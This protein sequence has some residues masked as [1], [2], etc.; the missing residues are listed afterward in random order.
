MLCACLCV[1]ALWCFQW[2][3]AS[4]RGTL[5]WLHSL[6]IPATVKTTQNGNIQTELSVLAKDV[7]NKSCQIVSG[8]TL[9]RNIY[10][11]LWRDAA[12]PGG[13]LYFL[14]AVSI[15]H[16]LLSCYSQHIC[17]AL[18]HMVTAVVLKWHKQPF[19][20]W[21]CCACGT[22]YRTLQALLI[23]NRA[24]V[25]YSNSCVRGW[26][27]T[28]GCHKLKLSAM[29]CQPWTRFLQHGC[30]NADCQAVEIN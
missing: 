15:H 21:R 6:M 24:Q 7:G 27:F 26:V 29:T 13:Q 12:P 30:F 2:L 23:I 20:H 25:M 4:W 28:S 11:S 10:H 9:S 3:T 17:P 16:K 5:Y 14:S 18:A 8:V 1:S 22:L 19:S